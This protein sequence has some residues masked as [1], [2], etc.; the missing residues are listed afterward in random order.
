MN[1]TICRSRC[2]GYLPP[3]VDCDFRRLDAG[4]RT[5]GWSGVQPAMRFLFKLC[6]PVVGTNR[7]AVAESLFDAVLLFAPRFLEEFAV[8]VW[9]V[10][11]L[12]SPVVHHEDEEWVDVGREVGAG[13]GEF[14][15][16]GVGD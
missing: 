6:N 14:E 13:G 11:E 10:G 15:G 4:E 5:A 1:I 8:A 7:E 16:G 12:V 3:G 9:I 2:P